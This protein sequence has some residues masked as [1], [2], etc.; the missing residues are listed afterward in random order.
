MLPGVASDERTQSQNQA[1]RT[2]LTEMQECVRGV[3]FER[4][5]PLFADDVVAFGT[6][7]AVVEGRDR[8]EREQWRNVWPNIRDFTFRLDELHALGTESWICVIV[9][10]DSIGQRADGESFSRPGR[11]TLVLSRRG[12]QWVATHSHFSLAP[13]PG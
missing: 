13:P 11:A 7:A 2:F 1:A 12:N 6:F 5:R 10:W 3:D 9:P 8:L 4:A